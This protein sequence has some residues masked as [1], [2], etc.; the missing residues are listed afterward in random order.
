MKRFWKETRAKITR[1]SHLFVTLFKDFDFET[2]DPEV[3]Q[4]LDE[5]Y[6]NDPQSSLE[7]WGIEG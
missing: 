5:A 2:S 1:F 3:E 6:A 4:E 7:E